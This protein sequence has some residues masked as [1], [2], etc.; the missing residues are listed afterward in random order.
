M[1]FAGGRRG[2]FG[3]RSARRRGQFVRRRDV[4]GSRRFRG[5]R[6]FLLRCF[7]LAALPGA[8]AALSRGALASPARPPAG[9]SP[10]LACA[11]SLGRVLAAGPN[12]FG[13]P[14][15]L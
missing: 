13:A 8:L 5:S 10:V 6:G 7:L 14:A 9:L 1:A 3:R 12:L 11:L 2:R 15:R 4:F